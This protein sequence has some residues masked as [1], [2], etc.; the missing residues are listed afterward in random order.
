MRKNKQLNIQ[1]PEHSIIAWKAAAKAAGLSLSEWMRFQLD[2]AVER[3]NR[4]VAA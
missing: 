4:V 1:A 2:A 3:R